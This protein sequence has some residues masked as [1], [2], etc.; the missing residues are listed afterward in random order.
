MC[1]VF[2][3]FHLLSM[4]AAAE[5]PFDPI[6][7]VFS[8]VLVMLVKVLF[9]FGAIIT[10]VLTR[11]SLGDSYQYGVCDFFSAGPVGGVVTLEVGGVITLEYGGIMPG[12]LPCVVRWCNRGAVLIISGSVGCV[13]VCCVGLSIIGMSPVFLLKTSA[14]FSSAVI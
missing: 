7:Q 2:V 4:L 6:W 14:N 8:L 11:L 12:V 10:L 9:S 3:W 1:M 13:D 5:F